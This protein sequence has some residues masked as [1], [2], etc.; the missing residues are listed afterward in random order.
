MKKQPFTL[1]ELL[2]VIAIIAILAGMLLPALN[3][4]RDRAKTTTC[5]NQLKQ[6]SLACEMYRNDYHDRMPPWISTLYP[7]YMSTDKTYRCP[8]DG[9]DS[10]AAVTAWIARPDKK[11]D[12]AYDV[13]QKTGAYGNP[14]NN[15]VEK[16]SYFYEF[17]EAPCS[18]AEEVGEGGTM[19]W[20]EYKT[21]NVKHDT[22]KENGPYKDRK[23]STFL[24]NFPVVRCFWH[25]KGSDDKPILNVSYNGN[26][27]NSM[28][29]WE[30]GTW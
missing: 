3:Q 21:R 6:L 30:D 5:L 12:E 24:S 13:P 26:T 22:C 28:L 14:T 8:K 7:N 17:S 15:D 29:K 25:L 23:Y 10:G 4:A 27:F 2:V 16:I 9:N 20:N 11:Y 1:I 19:T 18:F